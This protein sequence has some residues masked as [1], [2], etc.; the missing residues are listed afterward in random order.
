[1]CIV[2]LEWNKVTSKEIARAALELTDEHF[3]EVLDKIQK[4]DEK[5]YD[6]VLE[7]LLGMV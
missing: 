5:V 4:E 1:M 3:D 2:C 6:E 7:E